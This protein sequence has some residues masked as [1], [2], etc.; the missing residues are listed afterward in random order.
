MAIASIKSS[1]YHQVAYEGKPLS[2]LHGV[3]LQEQEI[4]MF[5]GAVP[6]RLSSF[7]ARQTPLQIPSLRPPI[8]QSQQMYSHIRIDQVLEFLTGDKLS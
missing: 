2:V 1:E 6:D 8:I 5:P 4:A 7:S 3:T